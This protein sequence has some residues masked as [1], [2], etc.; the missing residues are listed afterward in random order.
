MFANFGFRRNNEGFVLGAD[1]SGSLVGS[2]SLDGSGSLLGSGSGSAAGAGGGGATTTVSFISGKLRH[3]AVSER[4]LQPS[5][6]QLVPLTTKTASSSFCS[7][8]IRQ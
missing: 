7:L 1:G 4:G 3:V 8:N 5:P 2:G 6:T